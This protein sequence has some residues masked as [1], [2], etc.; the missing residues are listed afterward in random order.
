MVL[1]ICM[2]NPKIDVTE[3]NNPEKSHLAKKTAAFY[4]SKLFVKCFGWF[5]L[6]TIINSILVLIYGYFF[7]F[8][9]AREEFERIAEKILQNN[10]QMMVETYEKQGNL[11]FTK[12]RGLGN[13]W[14]YNEN[15]EVLFEGSKN[16][17]LD[18]PKPPLKPINSFFDRPDYPGMKPGYDKFF[19]PIPP[20]LRN[21]PNNQHQYDLTPR[22]KPRDVFEPKPQNSDDKED[23]V[24]GK[25]PL[26]LPDETY[27]SEFMQ[28]PLPKD[29]FRN[30][31][32]K[33]KTIEVKPPQNQLIRI[34]FQKFYKDNSSKIHDFAK[35]LLVK[36]GT[37]ICKIE[38]EVFFGCQLLS[39]NGNKYVGIIHIP[40][41]VPG[42]NRYFFLDKAKNVL[43]LILLVCAILCFIMARYLAKP[44]IELQEA[45]RKFAMGDFSQK[46]T[47]MSMNRYDEI[48]DLASDFN[49]MAEKI[50]AGINSQ[51]RLFNDIS[52]ELRSPLA[53]MQVGIELLQL[54]VRD[55]EKP[56]V[57]RL[58]KD[59][60]RMN[61][62]IEEV[63]QFSK[64]EIKQIE[65]SDEEISLEKALED[66][67]TDAEFE[68]KTN[69]RGVTLN[70]KEDIVIK[71]NSALIERAFENIIRNALRFTPDNSVV[72][73][74]L[75]KIDGN[76]VVKIAD[77][78]PGVPE[79]EINKIFAPFYCINS[80]RNPQKGGIGLGLS[81]ALRAIKVHNGTIKMSNRPEGG[82]LATIILP[83]ESS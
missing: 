66:V 60:N 31:P 70:I 58:E 61:A 28:K 54:K 80:D 76:A 13:F 1:V 71:G 72:E 39:D 19:P 16:N 3:N 33:P 78:G 69:H 5:I 74:S 10:G 83:I 21:N 51:K 79:E 32:I 55:S 20:E 75:E 18:E 53:R 23:S 68:G 41:D 25:R 43:P 67:C 49:N 36:S 12:F 47:K 6:I 81:I 44:I 52:H 48:G 56:L 38:D 37:N 45:S 59:V 42:Q 82:L 35:S 15:L 40:K 2:S 63:L 26:P 64:L 73:V 62:L 7:Y 29:R 46:I 22:P 57:G 9:P 14:L 34:R 8:K 77:H 24:F 65:T 11:Y 17:N 4:G 50:E 30:R 27:K